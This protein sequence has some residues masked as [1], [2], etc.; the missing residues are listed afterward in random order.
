MNSGKYFLMTTRNPTTKNKKINFLGFLW[1]HARN[2][3]NFYCRGIVVYWLTLVLLKLIKFQNLRHVYTRWTSNFNYSF[4]SYYL[5]KMTQARWV[6]KWRI[7]KIFF[8]FQRILSSS[9]SSVFDELFP[10]DGSYNYTN[11][12]MLIIKT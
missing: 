12:K 1:R 4:F 10:E 6:L 9:S 5:Q 7:F 8:T 11:F 2:S 3:F